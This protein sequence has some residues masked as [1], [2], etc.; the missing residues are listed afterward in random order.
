MDRHISVICDTPELKAFEIVLRE[1]SRILGFTYTITRGA[2]SERLLEE[3]ERSDIILISSE[4]L[5]SSVISAIKNSQAEFIVSFTP[6]FE[7]LEKGNAGFIEKAKEYFKRGGIQN[8]DG[9]LKL[10][11]WSCGEDIRFHDVVEIPWIGV[12]HPRAGVFTDISKFLWEYPFSSLPMAGVIFSRREWLYGEAGKAMKAISD[13]EANRYG[14]MPVFAQ[15]VDNDELK[16]VLED[17]KVILSY[18]G[19][20]EE[21]M[22]LGV[23]VIDCETGKFYHPD[24][25]EF[26]GIAENPVDIAIKWLE[27]ETK[28]EKIVKLSGEDEELRKSCEEKGYRVVGEGEDFDLYL[29]SNPFDRHDDRLVMV[30]D[31]GDE[32][33]S[34]HYRKP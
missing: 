8:I 34:R 25:P 18:A 4:D 9:L 1:E 12:Y 26:Q 6:D 27:F 2:E 29:S 20:S 33:T 15:D 11:L 31:K 21:L 10:A 16:K 24:F 3:I 19:I 28:D 22:K 32:K 5:S 30:E 14:V 13:I 7:N 23:P 17:V